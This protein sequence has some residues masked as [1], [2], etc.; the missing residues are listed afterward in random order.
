MLAIPI[1]LPDEL[2][3]SFQG[4]LMRMNGVTN[5]R[6]M[7]ERLAG[8]LG[9][10]EWDRRK[11]T[12][13]DILSLAAGMTIEKFVCQH[14][15]IPLKRGINSYLP[16][17]PHGASGKNKNAPATP[18]AAKSWGEV[19][20]LALRRAVRGPQR[21]GFLFLSSGVTKPMGRLG[22]SGGA[23]SWLTASMSWRSCARVL[24]LKVSWVKRR[25]CCPATWPRAAENL[26]PRWPCS[27]KA[28][29]PP[30]RA[31]SWKPC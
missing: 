5:D 13:T 15:L 9:V 17:L 8:V 3:R 14:T 26:P 29:R 30:A 16:D 28:A 18:L 27:S 10:S 6:E 11:V 21:Q 2:S 20:A 7:I 19:R 25:T 23:M 12:T 22:G 24:R 31:A 1:P 4:R